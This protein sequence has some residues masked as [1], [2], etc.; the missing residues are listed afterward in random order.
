[1]LGVDPTVVE[2][3][4]GLGMSDR[5]ILGRVELPLA[6]PVLLAGVRTAAVWVVGTATLGTPVGLPSLGYFI[7]AGL[8]NQRW[9]LLLVGCVAAALLAVLL[10][11]LLGLLERGVATRSRRATVG[12]LAGLAALFVVGMAGPAFS[13]WGAERPWVVGSKPFTEQYILAE[14][15]ADR[16]G[17]EEL[18]TS[19]ATGLGSNF[20]LEKLAAGEVDVMVD[21]TGTLWSNSMKRAGSAPREEVLRE[22][23]D[24]LER[25]RGVVL[26]GPVGFENA[27][28]LAARRELV[29]RLGLR[30][31]DDLGPRSADLTFGSDYEFLQRPE[32]EAARSAYGLSF[33]ETKILDPTFLYQAAGRGE[34]DVISAY[35]TDGRIDTFDLV[36]LDDPRQVIPPYDAVLLLSKRAAADRRVVEALR[37]LLG[38][39]DDAAMRAMNARIDSDPAGPTPRQV[40]REWEGSRRRGEVLP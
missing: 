3:A 15:I 37:P 31:L 16:L 14:V 13:R 35:T 22:V 10:D 5:Q 32:W 30:S 2:A 36:V 9:S 4:R 25:E 21:Y 18:P 11:T 39:I 27:Y 19:L 20:G 28:A 6:A 40:A 7:F 12:A 34:A 23:G 1:V 29:D 38:A 8:Q 24:W 26:L 17:H 33:R